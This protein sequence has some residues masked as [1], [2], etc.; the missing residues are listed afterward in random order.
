MILSNHKLDSIRSNQPIEIK[1]T[2]V[3]FYRPST[4]NTYKYEPQYVPKPPSSPLNGN[5][6]VR[7][8]NNR[9]I[10]PHQRENSVA[11]YNKSTT[12]T[13]RLHVDYRDRHYK[14]SHDRSVSF[15]SSMDNS[16]ISGHS[17]TTNRVNYQG[18]DMKKSKS[19]YE[20]TKL[21]NLGDKIEFL[22]S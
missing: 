6:T 10:S 3:D 14:P 4:S 9:N 12:N 2:N 8:D 7:F 17:K 22:K 15:K 11:S 18:Y 16:V 20:V 21:N 1:K 5:K 13:N 19:K